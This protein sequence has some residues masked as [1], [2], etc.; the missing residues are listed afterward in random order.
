MTPVGGDTMYAL[1]FTAALERKKERL[2]FR[3]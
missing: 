2:A 1:N 3:E